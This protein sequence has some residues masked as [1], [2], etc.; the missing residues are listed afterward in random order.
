MNYH[1]F[2][3]FTILTTFILL[4]LIY[5]Y[6]FKNGKPHCNHFI[7]NVYLYLALSFTIMGCFIHL[8]NYILNEKE[9][10]VK[11]ISTKKTFE[12]ISN[13]IILSFIIS[14]ISIIFLS[15]QPLFSKRGYLF[16]HSIWLLFLLSI[17]LSLYPYFKSKE[18]SLELQRVLVMVII[19]F[20]LMSGL[21]FIIPEFLKSTYNIAITGFLIALISIIITEVF[22]LFTGQYTNSIYKIISYFVIILFSLFISY[23]T[24]RLFH[25]AK[26]CVN[27]PNYPLVST[28]LFLDIIN[29]FVRMI[30]R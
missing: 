18:H 16:N 11:Y 12:Q 25:Y 1:N 26:I 17:S 2:I 9:D 14:L 6:A 21:V 20:L 3:F 15:L 19:I 4:C 22:L 10:I 8:Y 24:S 23:D 7:T 13:Y 28:N 29:L 5:K 30:N 27:S